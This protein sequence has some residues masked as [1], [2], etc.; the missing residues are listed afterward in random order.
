MKNKKFYCIFPK[1]KTLTKRPNIVNKKNK[2]KIMPS[3][4]YYNNTMNTFISRTI[5]PNNSYNS[6]NFTNNLI[7]LKTNS[8]SNYKR[9]FKDFNIY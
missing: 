4:R 1:E 8:L 5:F 2:N 3:I 9:F 6:Y 7:V